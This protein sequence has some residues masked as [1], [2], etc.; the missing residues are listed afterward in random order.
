MAGE[1]P[2]ARTI[3]GQADPVAAG[4][5]RA[6]PVESSLAGVVTGVSY[7]PVAAMNGAATD[8]RTLTLVNKGQDGSGAVQVASV[9][10]GAGTNANAHDE[11]P[12]ALSGT[13]AN[14]AVADGD[15]LEFVSTHIGTG[16]ADPGGLFQVTVAKV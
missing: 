16:I 1:A 5:D 13:P 14:L 10:F 7:V 11:F 12:L 6:Y 3:Q 2:L 4:A 15:I 8:N 9:Q